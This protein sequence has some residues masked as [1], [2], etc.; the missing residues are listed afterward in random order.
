MNQI[1]SLLKIV[2]R[3][4]DKNVSQQ[5]QR[6]IQ[7]QPSQ[8]E[9]HKLNVDGSYFGNS[10]KDGFGGLIRNNHGHW[11][12]GFYGSSIYHDINVAWLDGVCHLTTCG[13]DSKVALQLITDGVISSQTFYSLIQKIRSFLHLHW[14]LMF[15]HSLR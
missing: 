1:L 8:P 14:K 7:W 10:S 3:T 9:E 5:Q 6:L 2:T 11:I 13:S 4:C 15:R 12:V